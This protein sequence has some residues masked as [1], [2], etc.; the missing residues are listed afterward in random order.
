MTPSS[1]PFDFEAIYRGRSPL[2]RRAP[3]D[4]GEPQPALGSLAASG[5]LRGEV[6]DVG[7][8]TG[9]HALLI[10]SHGFRTTGVD[11]SPAAIEQARR[12]AE[13]RGLSAEFAV[14]DATELNSWQDR[15]DTV[16]DC[17]LFDSCTEPM[18]DRYVHALHRACRPGAQ[19]FLLELSENAAAQVQ[20]RFVELGVPEAVMTLLPRL[21]EKDL[22]K[23]FARDWVVESLEESSMLTRLPG[24]GT[25][26]VPLPAWFASVRR[27]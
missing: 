24:S 6:L 9:E 26:L 8:G 4:I 18:R 25:E 13:E 15:F 2:G 12:K 14:A 20:R 16:L 11:I 5:R 27:V 1:S 21:T 23:A 22:R 17:G 3:W 10:A 7:C 19:V